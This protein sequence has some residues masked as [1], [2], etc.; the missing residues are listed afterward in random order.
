[1]KYILLCGGCGNRITYSLPKPLNYINGKHSIEYV[2]DSIDTSEIYIIYNNKLDNYNFKEIIINKFKHINFYFSS[3]NF[4][5]RGAVETA[6]IGIQQFD[7]NDENILFIDNDNCQTFPNFDKYNNNFICY[8]TD[9]DKTKTNFSFITIENNYVTHIEEK[10]KISDN[11]CCGLY[12]FV[13][14]MEFINLASEML[15][16]NLKTINEFYFSRLYQLMLTQNKSI[17]PIFVNTTIHLGTYN[18]ILLNH[19]HI[20]IKKLRIC[21]D[22]D[23]TLVT[24]PTVPG[25]YTTVKPIENNINMLKN[26]KCKNHDI[27]IY[28][29]RRMGTHN[30]NVG[31]VMKDI[32]KITIDTLD[33]F[34]IP[35]DEL[36]FGKPIADIYIDDRAINPYLNNFN[37]MGFFDGQLDNVKIKNNKYNKTI[38]KNNYVSKTGSLEFMEGEIYFY[39]NIHET[40]KDLF[41][42][43]LSTSLDVNCTLDLEY[44]NGILLFD[45]YKSKTLGESTID[46]LFD[47]LERLHS[48][49]K[50]IIITEN[51][52]KNNYF[53]KLKKRFNNKQH[54]N[55]TGAE[56]VYVEIIAGLETYWNPVIVPIIHGDF[57]FSNIFVTYDDNIKLIDMR[58][59]IY[60]TI[61]TNGDMYYDYGKMYQSI[62]GYDLI[63][64]KNKLD[65]SYITKNKEYFLNK[66][67]KKGLCINYLTYVTKSLLFG[68]F[69]SLNSGDSAEE[70][71]E[72]VKNVK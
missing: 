30:G 44:I 36:L 56:K 46:K 62:L 5:T 21:F 48:V 38:I 4:N 6:Y 37:M 69:H 18:E 65:M 58:G 1:M 40:I 61:T 71:W 2:I 63:L 33:K 49:K 28:T 68:V 43:V 22:L 17:I 47:T 15:N 42:S 20:N 66:C 53:E 39:K 60:D 10:N 59:K 51:D 9:T 11:Y 24:Y 13:N 72:F 57:W 16:S 29:A 23:N 32:A 34:D 3:V 55:F 27:I 50:D 8:G 41:P 45:L 52:I 26:L 19:K 25:D 31:K 64:N 7:F 67:K 14:K 35:Y 70:I 12:G 54:Y